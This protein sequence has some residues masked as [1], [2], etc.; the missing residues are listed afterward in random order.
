[1]DGSM[2]YSAVEL[3]NAFIQAGEL[4]DALDALNPHLAANPTDDQALRLRA[5]VLIRL[6]S[7][8]HL[9][10]ALTDLNALASPTVND[11][12]QKANVCQM[13]GD[14]E[15]AK[16][17]ILAARILAPD[18]ENLV[19]HHVYMLMAFHQY[20]EGRA[21]IDS[22]PQTWVWLQMS[23]DLAS[24]YEGEERAIADYSRALT[25]LEV[26]FDTSAEKFAQGIKA[27]MLANRATMYATLER[28]TEAAADYDAARALVPDDMMMTF[29]RG[30][31]AADMG[32]LTEALSLCGEA[33]TDAN[34]T[35]RASMENILR[36]NPRFMALA[37]LLLQGDADV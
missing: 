17:A 27:N 9:R 11:L 15:S 8:E 25:L 19:Q 28:Y 23:G 30:L 24:E 21:L 18:Q 35:F 14:L 29:L 31:V 10:A 4:Q 1:M 26:A 34:D 7:D 16:Q 22:M 32:D 33:L 5:A 13:L 37:A 2:A 6:R 36:S 12:V 3:A 20:E